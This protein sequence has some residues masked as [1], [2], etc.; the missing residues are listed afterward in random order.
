MRVVSHES[1]KAVNTSVR[2]G[3]AYQEGGRNQMSGAHPPKKQKSESD[4][5][6]RSCDVH[7]KQKN[8]NKRIAWFIRTPRQSSAS[9]A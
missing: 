9:G 5:P 3:R 7:L 4:E 8:K 6:Q 1:R 2:Y